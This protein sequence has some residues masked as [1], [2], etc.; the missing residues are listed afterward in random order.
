[1]ASGK[2][3]PKPGEIPANTRFLPKPYALEEVVTQVQKMVAVA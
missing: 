1:M 3:P 2:A